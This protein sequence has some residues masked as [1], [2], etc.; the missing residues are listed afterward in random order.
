MTVDGEY[1]ANS[2][3]SHDRKTDSICQ[4]KVLV[5]IALQPLPLSAEFIFTRALDH[6]V[7]RASHF[8]KKRKRRVTMNSVHDQRMGF[9]DNEICRHD[10]PAVL[11]CIA[12]GTCNP[13]M[14]AV[15]RVNEGEPAARVYEKLSCHVF[16]SQALSTI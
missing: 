16:W 6:Q 14:R 3:V 1:V 9:S 4:R 7:R 10:T 13:G 8:S 12:K 2:P 11:Y 15:L 5:I